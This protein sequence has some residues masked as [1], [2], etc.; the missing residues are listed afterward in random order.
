MSD[1]NDIVGAEG[2]SPEEESRL[3]RVHELLVA[4]GP[5]PD[6]PPALEHPSEPTDA[7]IVQFPLLPRRRWALAAVL[8]ATLALIG[9]GGGYLTGHSHAKPAVFKTQRVV[10][11]QGKGALA[12]LHVGW[13]DGAGNWPMEFQV[14]GLPKQKDPAAYYELWLTRNGKPVVPCGS[15]RVNERNTTVHLS[16]PYTFS[17]FDGWVV[18]VQPAHEHTPGAVVLTT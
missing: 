14:S 18:T 2:L 13:K 10:S 4:A 12:V 6:L 8:A 5:P 3:R 11:M 17:R 9:F 15:F 7:E 16:V 1:F